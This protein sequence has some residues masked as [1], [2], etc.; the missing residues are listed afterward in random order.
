MIGVSEVVNSKI[1]IGV[2]AFIAGVLTRPLQ[3]E[4]ERQIDKVRMRSVLYKELARV[5]DDTISANDLMNR[6]AARWS[7]PSPSIIHVTMTLSKA[8]L[9][10]SRV[11]ESLLT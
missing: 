5:Y 7:S 10:S 9:S 6:D 11:W 1:F 4:I 8:T 2:V 3:R